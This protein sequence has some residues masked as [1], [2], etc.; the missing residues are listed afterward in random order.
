MRVLELAELVEL[1]PECAQP[2]LP[3]QQRCAFMAMGM[4]S[5]SMAR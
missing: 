1:L 4:L 2:L 3:Q 5:R